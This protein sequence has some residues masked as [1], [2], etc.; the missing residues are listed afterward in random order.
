MKLEAPYGGH[1]LLTSFNRG[2]GAQ[3][4]AP[5]PAT[6]FPPHLTLGVFLWMEKYPHKWNEFLAHAQK[7]TVSPSLIQIIFYHLDDKHH[8]LDDVILVQRNPLTEC[9]SLAQKCAL[10]M[11]GHMPSSADIEWISLDQ[12]LHCPYDNV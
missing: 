6:V 4:F 8:G 12:K 10:F 5:G 7:Q 1:L 9:I 2:S 11:P 3:A